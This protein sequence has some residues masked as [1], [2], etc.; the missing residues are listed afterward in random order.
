MKG[1]LLAGD[2]I[3]ETLG[4]DSVEVCWNK[5][6]TLDNSSLNCTGL[7]HAMLQQGLNVNIHEPAG[8]APAVEAEPDH[9]AP[10]HG[11]DMDKM[12][13]LKDGMRESFNC[14][15]AGVVRMG[16]NCY[17][18]DQRPDMAPDAPGAAAAEQTMPV[19]DNINRGPE[20][21]SM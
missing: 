11:L 17:L 14:G 6:G 21:F 12:G 1:A 20:T 13:S 15:S 19:I 18:P 5:N 4:G 8:A 7:S 10:G 16:Q 9:L 3:Q 2:G